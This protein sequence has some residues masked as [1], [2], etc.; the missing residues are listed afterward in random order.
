MESGNWVVQ[1]LGVLGGGTVLTAIV[2]AISSRKKIGAEATEKITAAAGDQLDNM[3]EDLNRLVAERN[4]A[5]T[6]RNRIDRHN[7]AWWARADVHSRW[8]RDVMRKM[9]DA[10]IPY[11]P[12]PSVYPVSD[13]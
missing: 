5:R 11:E 1:L 3:R 7:R 6:E 13:E 12:C 9:D 4:E 10:G 8:D 2:A